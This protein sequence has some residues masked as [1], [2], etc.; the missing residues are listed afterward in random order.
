LIYYILGIILLI[1]IV[2]LL[3]LKKRKSTS[4]NKIAKIKDKL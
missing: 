3:I 4:K 1:G 2:I